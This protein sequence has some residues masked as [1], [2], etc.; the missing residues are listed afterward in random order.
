MARIGV[1]CIESWSADLRS[2]SSLRPLL[3]FLEAT[4]DIN[5]IHQRVRNRTELLNYVD[6]WTT[7][8]S[9]P[10]G[11]LAMHGGPGKVRAGADDVTIEDLIDATEDRDSQEWAIDLRGKVLYLGACSTFHTRPSRI[12]ALHRKTRAHVVCGYAKDVDW[13]EAAAFEVLLFAS[14][15]QRSKRVPDAIRWL[16]KHHAEHVRRLR[17]RTFPEYG[18]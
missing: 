17:F 6:I 11:F 13:Y 18:T 4:D 2:K 8:D 14:L 5:V 16:H 1:F 12:E 7:Y 15:A 9:Y 10:V 3:E